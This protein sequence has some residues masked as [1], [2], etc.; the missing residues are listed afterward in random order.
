MVSSEKI[1]GN[2]LGWQR[3]SVTFTTP[4][5]IEW[6]HVYAGLNNASGPL[7]ADCFQVEEGAAT[8][9]YNLVQNGGFEL[10]NSYWLYQD[11][12]LMGTRLR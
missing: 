5:N 2:S 10:N 7:Y 11:S 4:S 9:P 12:K 8:S 3:L 6:M 1:S